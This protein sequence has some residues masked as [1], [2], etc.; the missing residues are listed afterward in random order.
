MFLAMVASG[1][2]LGTAERSQVF[3]HKLKWWVLDQEQQPQAPGGLSVVVWTGLF[4]RTLRSRS[5]D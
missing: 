3:G 2:S 1:Y 4:R 5:R